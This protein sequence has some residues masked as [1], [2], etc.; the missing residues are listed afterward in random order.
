MKKSSV[1]YILCTLL[2]VCLITAEGIALYRHHQKASP[3][4]AAPVTTS[5][6]G[7]PD[8]C[9]RDSPSGNNTGSGFTGGE[10]LLCL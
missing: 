8:R 6:S 9:I 1:K 10:N 5:G 2:V 7:Q 3:Q 4:T